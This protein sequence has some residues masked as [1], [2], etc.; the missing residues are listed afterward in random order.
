MSI[1]FLCFAIHFDSK[2]ESENGIRVLSEEP[3]ILVANYSGKFIVIKDQKV[4]GAYATET[5]AIRE[6]MKSHT[7]G[8]FLVQKCE[9][10]A[11]SYTQTFHSRVAFA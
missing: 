1:D 11:E 2:N 8:T 9:P 6:T 5:D 3:I 4:F 10:G 7:L